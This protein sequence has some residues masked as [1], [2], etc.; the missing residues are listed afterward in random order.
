M[1]GDNLTDIRAGQSV[2]CK[3]I[4]IGKKK[5]EMCSMMEEHGIKPDIIA[6]NLS[7]AVANILNLEG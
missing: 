5:C 4:L 3:T 6:G 1:V 7:A 2:G